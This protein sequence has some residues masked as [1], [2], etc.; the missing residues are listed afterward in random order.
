MYEKVPSMTM[1]DVLKF[2]DTYIKNQPK[3]YVILGNEKLLDFETIEKNFG[4]ITRLQPETY[5]GY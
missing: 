2:N 1:Q 4:K 3:T 5:F